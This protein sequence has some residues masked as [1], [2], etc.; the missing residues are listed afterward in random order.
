MN[1]TTT[2]TTQPDNEDAQELLR[3]INKKFDDQE[4]RFTDTEANLATLRA[5][6]LKHR[7]ALSPFTWSCYGWADTDID[8][9]C[10]GWPEQKAKDIAR[11]LGADGWTRKRSPHTCGS[12]DWHKEMDGCHLIIRNAE[13]INPKLVETVKL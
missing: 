4:K 13:N 1:E 9:H 5:F 8:F 2:P 10:P 6:F 7:E 12:I 11:A 3:A